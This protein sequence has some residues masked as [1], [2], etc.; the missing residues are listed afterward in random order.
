MMSAKAQLTMAQK[1]DLKLRMA[2]SNRRA[3]KETAETV[4]A[5]PPQQGA[6]LQVL[7]PTK[8][9]RVMI[10]FSYLYSH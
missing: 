2:D 10:R 3:V 7:P 6:P 1:K 5:L 8:R 4:K 9:K